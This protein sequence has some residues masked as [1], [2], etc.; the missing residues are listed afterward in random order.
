MARWLLA[1]MLIGMSVAGSAL[2][3][4]TQTSAPITSPADYILGP[5]DSI[6]ISVYQNPDLTLETRVGETGVITYPLIGVIKLS[7]ITVVEAEK[8]I[9]TALKDGNF[10]KQPQVTITLT[11]IIANQ[12]YVL[13]RVGKAGKYSLSAGSQR[14][15]EVMASAGGILDDGSDIVVV[16]GTRNGQPFRKEIDFARVFSGDS[17]VEDMV[18][19]KGDSIW[20]DRAP[21]FYIY[22]EVT[23]P[24]AR[25]LRRDMTVLQAIA[26]AGGLNQRGTMRGLKVH[27]KDANGNV[28]II[29]PDV[30]DKLLPNDIIYIKESLF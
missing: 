22:G 8:R 23:S 9:A 27:R 1:A 29:H 14:L 2:A 17:A 26:S 19:A 12:V 11:G 16:T 30:N 28:Q 18:L 3:Q 13:G 5:G 4:E 25:V 6:R 7:D 15:S 21:I 24:G 10:L 20:V